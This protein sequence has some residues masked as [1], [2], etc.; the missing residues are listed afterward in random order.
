M[1]VENARDAGLSAEE[2]IN[3]VLIGILDRLQQE[4][5]TRFSRLTDQDAK[6]GFLLD[7]QR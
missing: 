2:E 4:I 6:F 3:R 1:P 5:T 7:V